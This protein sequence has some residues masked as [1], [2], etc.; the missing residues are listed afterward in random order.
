LKKESISGR[1]GAATGAASGEFRVFL[2]M[3]IV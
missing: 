2:G 1:P 3:R